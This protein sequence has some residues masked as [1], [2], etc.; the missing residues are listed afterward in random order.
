VQF[1]LNVPHE[2]SERVQEVHIMIGHIVCQLVE[3]SLKGS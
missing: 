1:H 2:L 3:E